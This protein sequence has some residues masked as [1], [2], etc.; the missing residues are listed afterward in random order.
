[1]NETRLNNHTE[2]GSITTFLF[3]VSWD[4]LHRS[5]SAINSRA[6]SLEI[7][8]FTHTLYFDNIFFSSFSSSFDR[9]VLEAISHSALPT[10]R[11]IAA[12]L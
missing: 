4:H 3:V 7:I 12:S 11:E 8:H 10:F 2:T 6:K 5:T 9:F 1:M